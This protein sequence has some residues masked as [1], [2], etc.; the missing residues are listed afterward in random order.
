MA[1]RFRSGRGLLSVKNLLKVRYLST[2]LMSSGPIHCRVVIAL[3]DFYYTALEDPQVGLT[4]EAWAIKFLSR[5]ACK[6]A[7]SIRL[8]RSIFTQALLLRSLCYWRYYGQR[9]QRV[10]LYR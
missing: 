9:R 2:F 10:H 3:H 1:S 4:R 6:E 8:R 5:M 7:S